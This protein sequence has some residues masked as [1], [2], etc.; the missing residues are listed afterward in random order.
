MENETWK[1]IIGYE[2]C[3]SASSFGRIRNDRTGHVLAGG[4]SRRDRYIRVMLSVGGV[5]KSRTVHS[6]VAGAFLGPCPSGQEV[7]HIDADK[8]NNRALNL[9][10]VTKT[11]NAQ[12]AHA[13]RLYK[14]QRIWAGEAERL[15]NEYRAGASVGDLAERFGITVAGVRNYTRRLRRSLRFKLSEDDVRRIRQIHAGGRSQQSI[16]VEYGVNQTM[17]GFI[18]RRVSWPNPTLLSSRLTSNCKP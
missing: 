18:V 6:L 3:Y 2:G 15:R 11:Q 16:A 12:H 8:R 9:E 14:R 10:Y 7:N 13:N 1:P 17:I 5:A 4:K